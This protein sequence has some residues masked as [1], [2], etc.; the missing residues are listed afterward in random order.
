MATI[1]LGRSITSR[2]HKSGVTMPI[3]INALRAYRGGDPE[4]VRESEKRRFNDEGRRVDKIIALDEEWRQ[5]VGQADDL[6]KQR[7][8]A[9]KAVI[10]NVA[11]IIVSRIPGR[12]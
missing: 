6:R 2:P 4:L 8:A 9:N 11:Q 10:D 1:F 7:A 12:G 3:D 5:L